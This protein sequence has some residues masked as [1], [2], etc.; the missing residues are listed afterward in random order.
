MIRF[1]RVTFGYG[2]SAPLLRDFSLEL[3]SG[4]RICLMAPSGAGKTTLLRLLLGLER[5]DGGQITGLA[6]RRIS[7]VFQEDR[8]LDFRNE[9]FSHYDMSR[10]F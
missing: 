2:L 10:N 1:D 4:R 5:P 7:A 8:L 3:P 9:F 6:G